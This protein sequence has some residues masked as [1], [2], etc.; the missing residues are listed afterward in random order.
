MIVNA[1]ALRHEMTDAETRLWTMLRSHRFEGVHFRRQHPIG[2]Y[3]ADFCSPGSKLVIELDGSQ[4]IDQTVY[5]RK[6]TEY[7]ES[8]SYR[9]IRFWNH[10]VLSEMDTVLLEMLKILQE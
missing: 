1:R 5:D 7:L 8:R 3:I 9:V 2:P 6:R 4:H 10:E